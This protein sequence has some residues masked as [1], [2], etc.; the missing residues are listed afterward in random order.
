MKRTVLAL[1]TAA[2]VSACTLMPH[3]QRPQ[4]PAP[5][6]WPAD[7]AGPTAAVPAGPAAG[8]AAPQALQPY[9]GPAKGTADQSRWHRFFPPP[10][11]HRLIATPAPPEPNLRT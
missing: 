8:S 5:E 3:Y 11:P 9:P 1:L 2:A 6:H 7:A 10:G 4:S